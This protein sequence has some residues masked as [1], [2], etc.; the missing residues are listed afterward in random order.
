MPDH[1]PSSATWLF[2][3]CLPLF[4]QVATKVAILANDDC[5]FSSHV[6]SVAAMSYKVRMIKFILKSAAPGFLIG[7]LAW[8]QAAAQGINIPESKQAMIAAIQSWISNR[9]GV[10]Q[11]D[12][13][14][15]ALDRRLQVPDCAEGFQISRPYGNRETVQVECPVENWRVIVS[16][17]TTD[18]EESWF[19]AQSLPA[20]HQI[21]AIDIR[22]HTPDTELGPPALALGK[23]LKIPVREGQRL[24]PGTLDQAV[25]AYKLVDDLPAGHLLT[26]KDVVTVSVAASSLPEHVRPNLDEIR[27]ARTDR[28]LPAGHQLRLHDLK[29]RRSVLK[30]TA[31]I[32][33]GA[34]VTKENTR[35]EDAWSDLPRDIFPYQAALPR[36]T[37]TGRISPGEVIRH[38]QVRVLPEIIEGEMV[39]ARITRGSL[40]ISAQLEALE[41]GR[42]G[43]QIRLRNPQSGQIVTATV[44]GSRQARIR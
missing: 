35:R 40:E 12:I 3:D 33:R 18:R 42:N 43:Q 20:G 19:F 26:E 7:L 6:A 22:S 32:E 31:L 38:S 24:S 29:F 25:D 15:L 4:R 39:N 28:D 17:N 5:H 2:S 30:A 37:A 36:V 23:I 16:V 41:G 14:V 13:N 21:N 9:D 44:S 1:L 11:T 8:G 10:A 34:A 27:G